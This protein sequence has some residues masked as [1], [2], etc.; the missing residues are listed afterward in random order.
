VLIIFDKNIINILQNLIYTT[1]LA[2][3][4]PF[5]TG[6][7]FLKKLNSRGGKVFFFY[8]MAIFLFLVPSLYLKLIQND[9]VHQLIVNRLFLVTEFLLLS[10]Y[11][12][13]YVQLKTKK[14]I[15]VL[16]SVFFMAYSFYDYLTTKNPLEFSFIP[17]VIECLFFALVIIYFFYE[18]L[19]YNVSAPILHTSEFWVSVAFLLYFSG[20]FFLFLFSKSNLNDP[21]FRNQ[22][23]IIYGSVTIIKDI[24]LTVAIIVNAYI[25]DGKIRFDKNIDVDLGAFYPLQKNTNPKPQ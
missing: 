24:L 5:S 6:L 16:S 18:K 21:N 15:L 22:Y 4:L 17:L 20:N 7:F 9:R 10:Q 25:N 8:V 3:L 13:C 2:E 23:I 12:Y 1:Y 11:Y 19:Q 14:I